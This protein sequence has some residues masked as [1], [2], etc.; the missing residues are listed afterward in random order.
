MIRADQLF[1]LII[2]QVT[3]ID[4]SVAQRRWNAL[5][6]AVRQYW[7]NITIQLNDVLE[8]TRDDDN[9]AS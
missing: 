5:P 2:C 8:S 3:G 4:S 1:S 6:Y 7:V 9:A